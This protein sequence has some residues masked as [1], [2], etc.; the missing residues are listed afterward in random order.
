MVGQH[1]MAEAPARV[2]SDADGA[3]VAVAAHGGL[4]AAS[5]HMVGQSGVV[6]EAWTARVSASRP[7]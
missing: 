2:G 4:E 5:A 3:G 6:P 1:W 7:Y